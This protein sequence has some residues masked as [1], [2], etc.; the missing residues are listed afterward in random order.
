MNDP[1]K[2]P[3]IPVVG[4]AAWSGTGKTSLLKG[5]IGLFVKQGLRTGVIKHAHHSFEIDY[6][7]KDS[8]ELRKAGAEQVLIG[9]RRRWALI[10][11]H[12]HERELE[13]EDY[14]R[15]IGH[16]ALD[17]ILVEGFKPESIPKIEL[18]RRS[19][20][21]PFLFCGDDSIIAVAIDDARDLKTTLP[22]LD[23]NNHGQIAQ[24]II[25][26]FLTDHKISEYQDSKL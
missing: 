8:F 4:L 25:D 16:D 22:V 12:E 20:N 9:S 5:L 6:P 24:F 21:K 2:I 7:G 23:L 15:L 26:R 19:L 18:H 17:I 14:L 3:A 10:V 1:E 11:E 13:F